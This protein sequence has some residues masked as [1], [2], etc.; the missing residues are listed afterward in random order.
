MKVEQRR[1]DG[2]RIIDVSGSLG[3]PNL[4]ALKGIF[5]VCIEIEDEPVAINMASVSAVTSAAVG[6]ILHLYAELERQRR[7]LAL[8]NLSSAARQVLELVE[9]LNFFPIYDTEEEAV[10]HLKNP[11]PDWKS[12]PGKFDGIPFH[13]R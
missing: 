6:A 10:H 4:S 13:I 5:S 7:P 9:L 8:F 2:I 12:N 3:L 1:R 11:P